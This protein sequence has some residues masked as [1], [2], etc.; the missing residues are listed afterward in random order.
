MAALPVY[1]PS[2]AE[3]KRACQEIQSHWT[4]LER[5]HRAVYKQVPAVVPVLSETLVRQALT[6][7]NQTYKVSS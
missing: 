3:I 4:P 6:S 1:L 5:R 7:R 2:E